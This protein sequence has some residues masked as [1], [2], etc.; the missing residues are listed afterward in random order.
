M[1]EIS[2]TESSTDCPGFEGN[3]DLYGLGIRI[4]VYLQWY[5][6]LLCITVDP[7]TSAET[8]T[9]NALFIFAIMVALLLAD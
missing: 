4:G 1:S 2:S 8:Y 7:G 9:A 6:T 5:S 3:P